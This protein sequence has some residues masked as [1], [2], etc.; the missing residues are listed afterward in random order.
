MYIYLFLLMVAIFSGLTIRESRLI[1][2][3]LEWLWGLSRGSFYYKSGRHSVLVALLKWPLMLAVLGLAVP[4]PWSFD[5]VLTFVGGLMVEYYRY[6][7]YKRQQ[8]QLPAPTL[9]PL[10]EKEMAN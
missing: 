2:R 7:Q 5:F 8:A 3:P 10:P 1:A 6:R 4:S 9:E